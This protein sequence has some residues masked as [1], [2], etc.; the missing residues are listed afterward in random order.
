MIRSGEINEII[1]KQINDLV[2][3][4][5]QDLI[6]EFVNE[7]M[8]YKLT[9]YSSKDLIGRKLLDFIYLEDHNNVIYEFDNL[10]HTSIPYLALRFK[11]KEGHFIWIES[12]GRQFVDKDGELKFLII[13]R[14]ITKRKIAEDKLKESEE[15]YRLIS[16]NANDLIRVLNDRFEFEYI[17]ENVHKRLL[18]FTEKDLIGQ[19]HLPFLHPE[20]IRHAIRSTVKN[21]KR[22]KGSYEARFK[23]KFG[24]YKWF[25]FAGKYFYNGKGHKKILSIARDINDRKLAEEKLRES[26]EKYRLISETAYDLIG[27]LNKK[28]KYEYMNINAFQQILGYTEED[29]IGKSALKFIHPDDLTRI[30]RTLFE[31]FKHGEGGAELRFRHKDGHWVWIESKGKGFYDIDGEFKALIISRDITERKRIDRKIKESEEKYRE[32]YEDAPNAYFSIGK[33]NKITNC[34]KAAENLLGYTKNEFKE[35]SV[36][37][38]YIND[39]NSLTK[40]KQLFKRFL[41]GEKV[42]DQELMIKKKDGTTIWVSLTVKPVFDQEGNI[43][44]SRSMVLDITERK[45]AEKALILSEEKYRRAFNR[46]NF[47]KDLFAHDI[48]NILHIINSSAELIP[49]HV[50]G[51]EKSKVIEDISNIIRK[52][53]ERGAKLVQNVNTLSQLEEEK[54]YTS[55]T[56]IC[57]L[58]E[59][60]IEFVNKAYDDKNINITIK[61]DIDHLIADANELLQDVFDNILI[62]SAKYN[63]HLS[64]E[65]DVNATETQIEGKKYIRMEFSDNGIGVPDDR[66]EIIFNRGNRELKGSKGM[67]IGLSLVK[68]IIKGYK[69]K[70]WVENKVKSDYSK[71]SKFILLIPEIV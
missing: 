7:S 57:K 55:P 64:I 43:I 34:N 66:K 68:K 31:G 65:I 25:E 41:K 5:N 59:Q 19:T 53:V 6:Y 36:L 1:V 2:S 21:L 37:D 71:G 16:E 63:E 29:I 69:G 40:A 39:E 50:G 23:D 11:H 30:S 24:N 3:I 48:N 4:I 47:Y 67:G 9:G 18:E 26:E 56:K 8:H 32:L 28:F 38:L 27:V 44:E 13:S 35:M 49:Y 22:G 46:A 58:M 51:S 15:K 33:E 17:N 42:Q 70:I 54:I 62:N 10:L 61:C 60:S 45:K 12:N 14:D 52:Q 20:D